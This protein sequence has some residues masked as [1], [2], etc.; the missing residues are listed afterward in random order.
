MSYGLFV[1]L[2]FFLGEYSK[3]IPH[4]ISQTH[5]N[6]R[7][8][9]NNIKRF[10]STT[11]RMCFDA[12]NKT[13]SCESSS[14]ILSSPLFLSPSSPPSFSPSCLFV[15]FDAKIRTKWTACESHYV[16]SVF[17]RSANE[18]MQFSLDVGMNR[19]IYT[20]VGSGWLVVHFE[21]MGHQYNKYKTRST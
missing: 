14:Q 15:L 6:K 12:N 9:M 1:F 5:I 4:L 11:H 19:I 10:L 2:H 7:T 8:L 20:Y 3:W 21:H 17:A 16:C 18:T 13:I